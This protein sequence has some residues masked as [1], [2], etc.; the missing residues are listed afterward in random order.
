MEIQRKQREQE[1]A[2]RLKK[3][4]Q[5][6]LAK[7]EEEEKSK[8]NKVDNESYTQEINGKVDNLLEDLNAVLAEETET[9]PTMQNGT[10]VPERSTARAHDQ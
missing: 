5:E 6:A 8:R 1:T 9:T 7:K 10:Y 3:E 4:E 2:E